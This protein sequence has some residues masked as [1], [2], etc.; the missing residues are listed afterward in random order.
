M[1]ILLLRSPGPNAATAIL[2]RQSIAACTDEPNQ[3]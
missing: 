1:T 2:L 3:D